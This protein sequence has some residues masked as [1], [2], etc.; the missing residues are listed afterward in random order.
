MLHA[1]S[2]EGQVCLVVECSRRP[3]ARGFCMPHYKRWRRWG[4]PLGARP[5]VPPADRFRA[6]VV[7]GPA[8]VDRPGLGNCHLWTGGRSKQGY[9]VFHPSKGVYEL[10]HRW[11]YVQARGAIPADLVVDHLCRVRTCVNAD[12]ME[13]VTNEENL[14]RGAGYGLRNGMRTTC[15]HGH[16]YTPENTYISPCGGIRCRACGRLRDRDRIRKKVA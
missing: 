7:V 2:Y 9:G 15:I 6:A 8:P 4:D 5:V 10:A 3:A 12:H 14:R 16:E 13:L 1:I 11:A